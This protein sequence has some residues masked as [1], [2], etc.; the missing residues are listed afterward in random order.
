M[1]SSGYYN[2]WTSVYCLL[3]LESPRSSHCGLKKQLRP[4]SDPSRVNECARNA[5][6]STYGNV[7]VKQRTLP[8]DL[9]LF[10]I[11]KQTRIQAKMR[12]AASSQRIT[13]RWSIPSLTCNTLPLKGETRWSV[14]VFLSCH[15]TL[16]SVIITHSS[17][18]RSFTDCLLLINS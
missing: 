5:M 2:S 8:E 3:A 13:P 6:I 9:T 17:E 18:Y 15:L 1:N 12:H 16:T 7:A 4:T 10:Q 11:E 14:L